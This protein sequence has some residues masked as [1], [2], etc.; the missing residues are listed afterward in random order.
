[1]MRYNYSISHVP[2]KYL[3]TANALS[4]APVSTSNSKDDSFQKEVDPYVNL[5]IDNLPA[6]DTRLKEIQ[7]QQEEDPI[8]IQLKTYCLQGWPEKASLKGPYKAYHAASSGLSVNKN[9]LLI[10]NRLVIPS[11][12]RLAILEKLHIG[13]QG[14]T[15]CRRKATQSVW[16]PSIYKDIEQMI[17]KCSVC[18]KHKVQ[19]P[20]PLL[21]SALP[22]HPWKKVAYLNGT[23]LHVL[24]S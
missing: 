12:L 16:W 19:H 13:H 4:R 18:S 6:T 17:S 22:E 21:P 11:N 2:R 14:I 23:I 1:M 20:E 5:V 24:P 10:G 3:Y 7:P 15:K 8:C 9:L